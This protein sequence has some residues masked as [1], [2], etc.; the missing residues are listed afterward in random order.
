MSA[1]QEKTTQNNPKAPTRTSRDRLE[2]LRREIV[3]NRHRRATAALTSWLAVTVLAG[4]TL[5]LLR[6]ETF[7]LAS[8]P[9]AN[10]TLLGGLSLLIYAAWGYVVVRGKQTDRRILDLAGD[11]VAGL[12]RTRLQHRRLMD[13]CVASRT[14]VRYTAAEALGN[15]LAQICFDVFD[16]ERASVMLID[17]ASSELVV[18]GAVGH[19]DMDLVL[20][21][22]QSVG[23]GIAGWVAEHRK[24]ILL[25]PQVDVHKF[26]RF[27]PKVE[28]IH[29]A[30]AAPIV[31]RDRILGVLCVS[32]RLPE[33][34]Y[35]QEDLRTLQVLAW[36]AAMAMGRPGPE[37]ALLEPGSDD[38][39]IQKTA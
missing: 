12:N 11:Q 29:A 16:C 37:G 36:N 26:W 24:P 14:L 21:A 8:W 23:D 6:F 34:A 13:I 17:P 2:E 39:P 35:H 31:L 33:I 3:R 18:R 9:H 4:V 10:L 30:M 5:L 32:S 22:R 1:S 25:G 20:G 38:E 19:G 15:R 27:K 7:P 28:P